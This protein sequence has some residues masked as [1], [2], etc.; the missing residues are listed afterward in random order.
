MLI[1]VTAA[2]GEKSAV[3]VAVPSCCNTGA[4]ISAESPIQ[5]AR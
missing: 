2:E 4:L 1:D 3:Q 5:A